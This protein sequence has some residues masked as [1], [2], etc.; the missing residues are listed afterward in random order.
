M[1]DERWSKF[2]SRL[3]SVRDGFASM[4]AAISRGLSAILTRRE[5]SMLDTQHARPCSTQSRKRA[6][7]Y[8]RFDSFY[9]IPW[10][11]SPTYK[12]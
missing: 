4:R 12:N 2:L 1:K 5:P 10:L 9:L 3:S 11:A 7:R 8:G 6:A